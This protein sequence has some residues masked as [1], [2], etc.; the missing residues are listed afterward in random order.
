M[1]RQLP[2][3]IRADVSAQVDTA[4][5]R[6]GWDQGFVASVAVARRPSG[7]EDWTVAL[8]VKATALH[9][10]ELQGMR[11]LAGKMLHFGPL[12][13]AELRH[14]RADAE[15]RW[16]WRP[17]ENVYPTTRSERKSEDRSAYDSYLSLLNAEG[18]FKTPDA[19]MQCFSCR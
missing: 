7:Y 5:E 1:W 8:L 18:D 13:A 10:G 17:S 15:P 19:G 12:P 11:W 14:W 4:L 16:K 9:R 6:P 3:S 2:Q